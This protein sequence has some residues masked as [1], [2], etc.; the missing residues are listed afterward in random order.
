MSP[1]PARTRVH[2]PG[3]GPVAVVLGVGNILYGDEGVGVYGARV[4]AE[5]FQFAPEVDVVDGATLGFSMMD[6][7][8]RATTLIVLDALAADAEPGSIF[9]LPADE[10]GRLG[11]GFRPAAHEVDPLH[12][13][14]MAPLLGNAPDLVLLGIVPA[15]TGIGVGLSPALEASFPRYVEAALCELRGHG[16]QAEAVAPLTLEDAVG[17][18]VG[19]AR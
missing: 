15:S 11:P 19:R 14:K 3:P 4:L 10:L 12:L 7:F 16:I 1:S 9:R 2:V 6:L 13:L 17:G 5:G 18:L 8:C